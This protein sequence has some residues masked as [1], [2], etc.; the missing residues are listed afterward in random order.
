M[1][2]S[3]YKASEGDFMQFKFKNI[4][5]SAK[6]ETELTCADF[7]IKELETRTNKVFGTKNT[8]NKTE[9][10][11]LINDNVADNDGYSVYVSEDKIIFSA[12]TVRG[13]IF[14]YSHFLRKC[15]FKN[16]EILLTKDISGNYTPEKKI[17]GHQ[18]GYRTTPN[19]YDAWD[20]D[21]YFRY[22]LDMMAFTTNTCEHIPYEKGVSKRNCLM[23]YDE[24]EFFF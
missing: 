13:L 4:F 9:V 5:I 18:V 11:F 1:I 16:N 21:Q 12:K 14:A 10:K 8:E 7:F 2:L 22:Y 3:I 19:T 17:R 15:E 23:K 24:E 6:T 20:Y